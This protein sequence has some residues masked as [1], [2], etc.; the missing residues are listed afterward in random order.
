[1]LLAADLRS[2]ETLDPEERMRVFTEFE[3]LLG[4]LA[5]VFLGPEP[6]EPT[7]N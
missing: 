4:V 3:H 6:V 2:I 1:M 7:R 5:E